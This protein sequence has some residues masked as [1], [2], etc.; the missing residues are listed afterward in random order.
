[1]HGPG[2]LAVGPS[3]HLVKMALVAGCMLR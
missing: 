2:V 1:V 3:A